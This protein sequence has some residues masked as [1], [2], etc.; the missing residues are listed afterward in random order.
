MLSVAS[1][2]LVVAGSIAVL[3]LVVA[4]STRMAAS[5]STTLFLAA[6]AVAPAVV[7][8]LLE[9]QVSAS[10]AEILHSPDRRHR[11]G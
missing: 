5:L 6:L 3:S 2:R 1:R 8:A 7:I 9:E 4:V 11:R 10:A